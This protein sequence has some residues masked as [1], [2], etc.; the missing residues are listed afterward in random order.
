MLRQLELL[1]TT[2]IIVMLSLIVLMAGFKA[3]NYVESTMENIDKH[4]KKL[5]MIFD[6]MEE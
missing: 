1:I 4:N 5:E 2:L 3:K 6:E